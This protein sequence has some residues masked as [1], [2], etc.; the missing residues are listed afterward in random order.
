MN[1]VLAGI[2]GTII[3]IVLIAF[4]GFQ[5]YI[6]WVPSGIEWWTEYNATRDQAG[7]DTYE[8]KKDVEDAARALIVSYEANLRDYEEAV[9]QCDANEN[10]AYCAFVVTY[11][12]RVNDAAIRFNEYMLL[13]SFIW[14]DNIPEDIDQE[15]LLID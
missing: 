5:I 10:S 8:N 12:G 6:N 3:A 7:E 13:N 9:D 14:E 11:K 15:L 4:I 1:R 2:F